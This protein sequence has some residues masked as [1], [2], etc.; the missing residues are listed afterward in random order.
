MRLQRSAAVARPPRSG[1]VT[2]LKG[3]RLNKE[4]NLVDEVP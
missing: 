3:L 4:A 1:S 2:T